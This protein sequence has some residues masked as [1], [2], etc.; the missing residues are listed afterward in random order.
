MITK[1]PLDK[2]LLSKAYQFGG[3]DMGKD[4]GWYHHALVKV[5]EGYGYKARLIKILTRNKII[6][7]LKKGSC[8]M[9]S[10]SGKLDS[11]MILIYGIKLK[12]NKSYFVYQDPASQTKTIDME[13]FNSV[14][15]YKGLVVAN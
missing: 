9:A 4:I 14:S 5:L 1:K 11:H 3:Y 2:K 12:N 7:Y 13:L 15:F 6:N 10:V 8:I